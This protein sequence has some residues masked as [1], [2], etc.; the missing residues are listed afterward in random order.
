M[1]AD[2]VWCAE[3]CERQG[4]GPLAVP[5]MFAAL[6]HARSVAATGRRPSQGAIFTLAY[7]VE[8]RT[9]GRYR[10][11]PAHIDYRFA[12]APNMVPLAMQNLLERGVGLSPAE[13]YAEFERIHPLTDGNGRVGAILYNWL[14]D[15][16]DDPQDAPEPDWAR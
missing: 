1:M 12:V 15:T 10:T 3:Q 6:E 13:W 7:L 4:A 16:L 11:V 14:A 5:R 8:P 9:E 2:L